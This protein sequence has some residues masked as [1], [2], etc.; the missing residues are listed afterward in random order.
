MATDDDSLRQFHRSLLIRPPPNDIWTF[1]ASMLEGQ[2]IKKL[3]V[4]RLWWLLTLVASLPAFGQLAA[5]TTSISSSPNP[6]TY[7]QSLTLTATVTSASGTPTG[8]VT[9]NDGLTTLGSGTLDGTGQTTFATSSL[10]AGT[11]SIT[12]TYSGDANFASGSSSVL[13]QAVNQATTTVTLTSTINPAVVGQSVTFTATVAGAFGGA[14]SGTITFKQGSTTLNTGAVSGNRASFSTSTLSL[15]SHSITAAYSGDSNFLSSVSNTLTEVINKITTSTSVFSAVNPAVIG[16]TVMFTGAVS[17][18]FG[19]PPDGEMVTFKAGTTVL[20][21]AP[22]SSGAASFS[23]S[24]ASSGW[25]TINAVYAG[26]SRFASSKGSLTEKVNK[27]ATNTT[28]SSSLNPSPPGSTVTFAVTVS[29]SAGTPADGETITFKNGGVVLGTATLAGGSA[30]FSSAALNSGWNSITAVYAG[31]ITLATSSGVLTQTVGANPTSWYQV[32]A[33][34][35]SVKV[36]ATTSHYNGWSRASFSHDTGFVYMSGFQGFQAGDGSYGVRNGVLVNGQPC[37]YGNT[38]AT[39]NPDSATHAPVGS[40]FSSDWVFTQTQVISG[41]PLLYTSPPFTEFSSSGENTSSAIVQGTFSTASGA[42]GPYLSPETMPGGA[43]YLHAS[44]GAN[45]SIF[46]ATDSSLTVCPDSYRSNPNCRLNSGSLPNSGSIVV[47]DEV[48][49]F[50]GNST[51]P[52]CVAYKWNSTTLSYTPLATCQNSHGAAKFVLNVDS[53]CPHDPS[54]PGT[55]PCRGQ[56]QGAGYLAAYSH[57]VGSSTNSALVYLAT[58]KSFATDGSVLYGARFNSSNTY[59]VI[60]TQPAINGVCSG[61]NGGSATFNYGD[62]TVSGALDQRIDGHPDSGSGTYDPS[63]GRIWS[64]VGYHTELTGYQP[65]TWYKDVFAPAQGPP[66]KATSSSMAQGWQHLSNASTFPLS[67]M[68]GQEGD[69]IYVCGTM[70]A[71]ICSYDLLFYYGGLNTGGFNGASAASYVMCLSATAV[72]VP[73]CYSNND[74]ATG[75]YLARQWIPTCSAVS[76]TSPSVGQW[77]ACA[78]S[79]GAPINGFAGLRDGV[80]LEWDPDDQV[81]LLVGGRTGNTSAIYWTSVAQWNPATNNFCLSDTLQSTATYQEFSGS[82]C[83]LPALSGNTP[84]ATTYAYFPLAAWDDNAAVAARHGDCSSGTC[85]GVLAYV[86]SFNTL[87]D[88]YSPSENAWSNVSIPGWVNTAPFTGPPT[89]CSNSC[90]PSKSMVHD[91]V[92]NLLWVFEGYRTGSD[93]NVWELMDSAIA[94]P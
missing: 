81:V 56:R 53:T 12:A 23:T 85:K 33:N 73:A 80:R 35:G 94:G 16:Q 91:D 15:G 93:V 70:T 83:S 24:F 46:S 57:P 76:R 25:L 40:P 45:P 39:C 2:A 9:F 79:A 18:A 22:L 74:P 7:G 55:Q 43:F 21:T 32:F 90:Q 77:N 10:S 31:D 1:A 67:G 3:R 38:S 69:A 52:G 68:G 49:D 51:T 44:G 72:N 6:S 42:L 92:H 86:D 71:G 20:G 84:S 4:F 47:D 41:D 88:L 5:T 61:A 30:S 62:N 19:P 65:Y 8:T 34:G 78:G 36:S 63:R 59:N 89:V 82:Q 11:H 14:S 87:V 66:D 50:A 75:T 27:I 17:S 13:S 37:T 26:D 28:V 64:P 60:C 58:P 29:S 48:I 54:N